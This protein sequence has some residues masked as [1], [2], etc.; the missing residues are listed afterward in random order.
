M[1]VSEVGRELS[2]LLIAA[3]ESPATVDRDGLIT[4]ATQFL[5][6]AHGD[7]RDLPLCR[8][9]VACDVHLSDVPPYAPPPLRLTPRR[10]SEAVTHTKR[11][12]AQP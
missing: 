2:R 9:M 10:W 11:L 7:D 5:D 6:V 4:A 8:R 1:T 12:Y 3:L